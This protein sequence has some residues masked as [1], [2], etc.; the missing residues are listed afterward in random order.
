MKIVLLIFLKTNKYIY[1]CD[2]IERTKFLKSFGFIFLT[3][4]LNRSL[5]IF[6]INF[7]NK[8]V[9]NGLI[10]SFFLIIQYSW[11]GFNG[12]TVFAK[13][14]LSSIL[15][16]SMLSFSQ[17]FIFFFYRSSLL[18]LLKDVGI[19]SL[20]I[21]LISFINDEFILRIITNSLW[22]FI[23]VRNLSM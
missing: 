20:S 21:A 12:Q 10:K 8:I 18:A 2:R 4:I 7:I 3:K 13:D 15:R 16:D 11:Y 22:Y 23:V 6:L 19:S 9:W 5:M 17:I 1:Y 14:V